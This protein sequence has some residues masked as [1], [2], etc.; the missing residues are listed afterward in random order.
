MAIMDE[1][2]WAEFKSAMLGKD[3]IRVLEVIEYM[4]ELRRK[5]VRG[6][7]TSMSRAIGSVLRFYSKDDLA[8]DVNMKDFVSKK[9]AGVRSF[10]E[11]NM[12]YE[13]LKKKRKEKYGF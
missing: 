5:M 2:E 12:R 9:G 8:R 3:D 10:L 1:K 4:A 13:E 6:E 11:F 7:R